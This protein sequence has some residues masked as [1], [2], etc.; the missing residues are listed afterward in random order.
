LA[1]KI[2]LYCFFYAKNSYF[3]FISYN[4]P[5]SDPARPVDLSLAQPD[6]LMIEMNLKASSPVISLIDEDVI[7]LA[8]LHGYP[9]EYEA[10]IRKSR[11][12]A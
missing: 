4:F 9:P 11:I 5:W 12:A 7:L 1:P 8:R 2:G 10:V 6:S 3:T